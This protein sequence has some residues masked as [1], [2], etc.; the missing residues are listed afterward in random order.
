M[1]MS[2]EEKRRA[3]ASPP[4]F[5]SQSLKGKAFIIASLCFSLFSGLLRG[6]LKVNPVAH[7]YWK[8][9]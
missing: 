1:E 9:T 4:F 2:E 3:F 7:E 5:L 8:A 6:T